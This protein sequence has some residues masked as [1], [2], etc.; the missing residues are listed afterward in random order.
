MS[1]S[2]ICLPGASTPA[3]AGAELGRPQVPFLEGGL[4]KC[5]QGKPLGLRAQV[6]QGDGE[7]GLAPEETSLR[8]WTLLVYVCFTGL[9]ASADN[10]DP[11]AAP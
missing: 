4:R 9:F 2:A 5:R 3:T 1:G 8:S 7:G 10:L 11:L 6:P